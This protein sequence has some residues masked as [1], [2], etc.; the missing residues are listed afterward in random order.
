MDLVTAEKPP[1]SDSIEIRSIRA[2][3]SLGLG[4]KKA[5]RDIYEQILKQDPNIV[6]AR[7]QLVAIML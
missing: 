2:A 1:Q 4:Q 6:G 5:A 3:A 7:R